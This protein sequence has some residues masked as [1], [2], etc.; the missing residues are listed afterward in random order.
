MD[1]PTKAGLTKQRINSKD[2]IVAI[3]ASAGGLE[4]I[5]ELFD[6]MPVDTNLSFVIV[7]H[8]SPDYKSLM[9]ELLAKH[10]SMEIFLAEDGMMLRENC[11]YLIPSKKIMTIKNR[12]L[13]LTEKVPSHLPNTA[14]DIFFT[15]L[16]QEQGKCAIGIVLSGTGTD[17]TKG[18]EAIKNAGGIVIVQDPVTAK[19]D[20]MPNSAAATGYAD[21][22]LPPELIAG[23]LHDFLLEAPLLKSFREINL[24][25]AGVL[26]EVLILVREITSYDFSHYK[27]PTIHRR[28]AKRMALKNISDLQQYLQLLQ[29]DPEEVKLL[30]K[31]FLIGV[32]R[33]FRDEE[34]FEEIKNLVLP[35][36]LANKKKDDVIKGWVVACSTGEEAYTYAILIYE[37]LLGVNNTDMQVKIFAT[38]IDQDALEIASRGIYPESV[39]KDVP[40]SMIEKY[41]VREGNK[42]KV[43]PVIRRMIVFANHDVLKD[44]P[45][46]KLEFISCRNMLIYMN[47]ELQKKV[48]RTFHFALN[49]GSYLIMGPSENVGVLKDSMEEISKKWKIVK[50]LHRARTID[51]ESFASPLEIRPATGPAIRSKNALNNLTEI[52]RETVTEE[53]H[54][55]GIYIDR[56]YEV[57]QAI[58]NFK[59]F[60]HFP[61]GKFNFNLLKLVSP[62]L[63]IA[64][65]GAV[66][67]AI[68]DNEKVSL[69]RVRIPEN[70]S[71]RFVSII[72]KPYLE[73]S[74]YLQ[75]FLFI[76]L[77]DEPQFIK[78]RTER[79]VSADAISTEHYQD[80]ADE[81]KETKE[82]LQAAIEEL[83]TANE[84]LQSS[85][86]EMISANEE[87]Q[88]TNEELQS[89]NEELHTVNA[90]HQ[91]KIKELIE[92]ND[93]LNN[94]FRNSGI[95]QILVDRNMIIRKFTPATKQLINLIETDLGRSIT[96]ISD[97]LLNMNLV[98]EIRQ[99]IRNGKIIEKDVMIRDGHHFQMR[100]SPYIRQDKSL[101]GV[102][103]TFINTTEIRNLNNIIEGVFNSSLNGIVAV[104]AVRDEKKQI[105]DFEWVTSN[106]ATSRLL[107]MDTSELSG[108]S[109]MQT[110]PAFEKHFL[111]QFSN[112][113]ESENTLHVEYFDEN[114]QQWLEVVAVKM[115]DGLVVTFTD[116]SDKKKA[117][118]LL[119]QGFQDLQSTTNK[120][121]ATN[122]ALEQSNYELLQFASVVSHDLKEPLRKI[123]TFGN[124]LNVKVQKKLEEDENTYLQKMINASQRM[125]SLIDDLLAFSKLS[126]KHIHFTDTDMNLVLTRILDDLEVTIREKGASFDIEPLPGIEAIPGQIHQLFQNVISNALK[127]NDS[128]HPRIKVFN[129]EITNEQAAEFRIN[130]EE[131]ISFSIQDN[132][133]GF[134]AKYKE[135]I[136]GVFQRLHS[137]ASYQG[138]GIGLAICKKIIENH[139]GFIFAES[140]LH[141]GTTFTIILPVKQPLA[142]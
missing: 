123:Q 103:I 14:I 1:A 89:L 100:I 71:S 21:L 68:K 98:S 47:T 65:S 31:E 63:S 35:A 55:A 28:L 133:I 12:T 121:T 114:N 52:F 70:G 105:T 76:V 116:I 126:N 113:V 23:E 81:L 15:S 24:K 48:L 74:E 39:V 36:I 77:N 136:F 75:P 90:E 95:G 49:A 20:G 118:D 140:E 40:P 138:T 66:R 107:H 102:V 131:Y 128:D 54:F 2:Y 10:T 8:L 129:N 50:N 141:K 17:G 86:E 57:K 120:L 3:G 88:S 94:Y 58:G 53:F 125:Q 13:Q 64:L 18:I 108:K 110:F 32:T 22:I 130:P 73:Q 82:N 25:D 59:S 11:I 16:A 69:K 119:A 6:Y 93:D 122:Y 142:T 42:F 80:L 79:P 45:F 101:D 104:K 87:L 38:D 84:E 92:L 106:I 127:F 7:Q 117:A 26:D 135:K 99:V 83:E 78:E 51:H 44:P 60:L 29:D 41:F 56:D 137:S 4:A 109:M 19:F 43:S 33:F 112:V 34:A 124:L 139:N 62:D 72:V 97:N 67:K 61:E 115:E 5:H 30:C 96:D 111:K 85:N 132:G 91:L 27:K 134:D 9:P 37:Y 46:S